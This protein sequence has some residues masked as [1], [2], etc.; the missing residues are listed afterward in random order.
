[1]YLGRFWVSP[2]SQISAYGSSSSSSL[3]ELNKTLGRCPVLVQSSHVKCEVRQGEVHAYRGS[4][5]YTIM[6]QQGQ[7]RVRVFNTYMAKLSKPTLAAQP[8]ALMVQTL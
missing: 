3:K 8:I 2:L 7:R 6:C 1:M 5:Q 4:M